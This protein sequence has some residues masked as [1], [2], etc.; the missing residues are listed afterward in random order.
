MALFLT[1]KKH[2]KDIKKRTEHTGFNG[3]TRIKKYIKGALFLYKSSEEP[4]Q[5]LKIK[6]NKSSLYRNFKI[7]ILITREKNLSSVT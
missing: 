6:T 7:Q 1:E 2:K 4:N 3:K 5:E